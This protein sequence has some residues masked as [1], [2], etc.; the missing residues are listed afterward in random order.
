M[1]Y[2][3]RVNGTDRMRPDGAP[4]IRCAIT[5]DPRIHELGK[6]IAN[7]NGRSLSG[8][9]EWLLKNYIT[10]ELKKNPDLLDPKK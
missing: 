7:V 9:I 4:Y 8:L 5:L 2:A 10:D 1:A 6:N 3:P